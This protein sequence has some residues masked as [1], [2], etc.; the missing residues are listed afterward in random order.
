MSTTGRVE[1]IWKKRG[2]G[3]VMDPVDQAAAVAGKGI[4]GDAN[5]GRTRQVTVIE[6]V[7]FDRIAAG[8]P[9]ATP[10]MRRANVM[11][12]GLRLEN[13]RDHVLTMGGMKIQIRG[14]TRPCELM[15]EQCPGL[16]KA[17]DLNWAGGVHGFVIQ[18]GPVKIGDAASISEPAG[19]D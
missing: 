12:S 2:K 16:R 5:F 9:D 13:T 14:E 1:Q 19:E 15:D 8:L 6:K 11:V 10:A 17:L 18:A 7:V 4:E 3:S